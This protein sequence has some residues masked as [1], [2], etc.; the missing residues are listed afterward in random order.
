MI[1]L[2]PWTPDLPVQGN[3]VYVAKNV[4]PGRGE[5]A[6]FPDL[7][8]NT[9]ALTAPCRGAIAAEAN[10]GISYLYAGDATKLYRLVDA[11]WTSAKTGLTSDTFVEFAKWG[12]DIIAVN[13]H[14]DAPQVITLGDTSFADLTGTPPKAK[15]IATVRDFVMMG[16]INGA[17]NKV[18][19]SEINDPETWTGGQ[20]DSQI[21]PDGGAVQK[22]VGGEY[23]IVFQERSIRR[24]TYV[25]SPLVFQIDEVEPGRGTNAPG[26]VVQYG[27][28]IFYY[29]LDG[30]YAFNGQQSIPIGFG[31]VDEWF[32]ENSQTDRLPY[33]TG[34]FDPV[35]GRVRWSFTKAGSIENDCII[36]YDIRAKRW[37][38]AEVT[39]QHLY[40]SKTASITLD[41]LDDY[42]TSVDDIP[43]SLDDAIFQG[44]VVY[45]AGFDADNKH[46]YFTGTALDGEIQTGEVRLSAGRNSRVT[47][48]EP[49][50]EGN[51]SI[52]LGYRQTKQD[53]VT[54]T[55]SVEANSYGICNFNIEAR[56]HRAKI[57][58]TG[59]WDKMQGLEIEAHAR[60]RR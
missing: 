39:V 17:P 35:A 15:H 9:S 21:F 33:M 40:Q 49:I 5:Y 31:Q 11:T 48:V 34:A 53:D 38:Y 1:E 42:Y 54:W 44:G 19:W 46:G 43:G 23:G 3:S 27:D 36:V 24:M 51:C 14:T 47:A 56:Y 13:G 45:M 30:F 22:I 26:S 29:G 18:Q 55:S 28:L 57:L 58:L 4:L 32:A 25:G 60:G 20:S 50:L 16:N 6:P 2:G 10:T 59:D 12:E 41:G 52:Q 37:T 7:S 8:V